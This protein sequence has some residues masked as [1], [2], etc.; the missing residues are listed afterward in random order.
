MGPKTVHYFKVYNILSGE[1]IQYDVKIANYIANPQ[2]I[3]LGIA[4]SFNT[5]TKKPVK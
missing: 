3:S 2:D 4:A 1:V 5:L